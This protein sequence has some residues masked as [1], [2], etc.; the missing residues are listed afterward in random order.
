MTTNHPRTIT[1]RVCD[2]SLDDE[3][4]DELTKSLQ[5]EIVDLD[6]ESVEAPPATAA[7]N[8]KSGAATLI[9][10]LSVH[11]GKEA[12]KPVVDLILDWVTRRSITV[13]INYGG[14]DGDT[15]KLSGI[16][17]RQQE[18]LVAEW[19]ECHSARDES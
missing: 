2:E 14:A 16:D 5:R 17:R 13:E 15:L 11:L 18:L 1:I 7:P 6:V 10:W 8:S 19:L 4:L 3:S 9:G 12:I